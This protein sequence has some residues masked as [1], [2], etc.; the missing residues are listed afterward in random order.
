LKGG[1]SLTD[2]AAAFAGSG[3][4]QERYG[5]LSNQAFVEQLYRFCLNREG[6]PGGV[7]GWV[8][9][10]NSGTSRASVLLS[11]SESAEH[12]A[13][14]APF[15]LGG[16]NC[17]GFFVPP[18]GFAS[19]VALTE[20]QA[21]DIDEPLVLP[22]SEVIDGAAGLGEFGLSVLDKAGDAFVLPAFPDGFQPTVDPT[23]P[24]NS[25]DLAALRATAL[26]DGRMMLILP[27]TP[28]ATPDFDLEAWTPTQRDGHWLA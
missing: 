27:E 17:F 16:I 11:F 1:A 4:F 13:L 5:S 20:A 19:P 8:A 2:I 22:D 21:K 15:W 23:D 6:D 3:E 28:E 24:F 7:A 26:N 18:P 10:L 25:L 9:A 14:T 12:V